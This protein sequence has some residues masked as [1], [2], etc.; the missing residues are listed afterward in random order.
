MGGTWAFAR[1]ELGVLEGCGQ[2]AHTRPLEATAGGQTGWESVV[3]GDQSRGLGIALSRWAMITWC[4]EATCA[5][6]SMNMLRV[7]ICGM[8]LG[9]SKFT[10]WAP[11]ARLAWLPGIGRVGQPRLHH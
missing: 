4:H 7:E 2:G 9:V 6:L 5:H 1:R 10:D 8:S 3:A 11:R